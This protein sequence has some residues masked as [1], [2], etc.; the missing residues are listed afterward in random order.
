VL[1]ADRSL[2]TG[3][4]DKT[5]THYDLLVSLISVYKAMGGGWVQEADKLQEPQK[6]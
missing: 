5:K 6:K 1:D 3:K 2:F 4:L